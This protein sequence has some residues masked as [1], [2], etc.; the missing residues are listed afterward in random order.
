MKTPPWSRPWRM[1]ALALA[2]ALA[3]GCTISL[4][5][6][7]AVALDSVPGQPERTP[8]Y[9]SPGWIIA[10]GTLHN[11]TIY[12]DGCRTAEDLLKLAQA[13]GMAV[14]AY[15]DHR[16]GK[17]CLG[18]KFCVQTG[19]V[20]KVGYAAYYQHLRRIQEK[21]Q[22]QGMIALKGVEV[23]SPYMAN[24][25]KFPRLV[26]A[27]QFQHFTVYA[28]ED[29]KILEQMPARRGVKLKPEP[30]P[31]DKPFQE[32][33]SYIAEH[34]GIVHAVHVESGQDEWLGPAHAVTPPPIQ[35]MHL[36]NLTGFSILPEGWHEK[37]GGPGGMWDTVLL[38]Y[39]AGMRAKP[40]WASGDADYHGPKGSLANSTTLFY[41]REFTEP[42]IYRAMR[43]GRM[44]ALQGA[45]FQN[46]FVAE[47]WVSDRGKPAEAVMLG[48]EVSMS[49]TPVIRFALDHA[50]PETRVRLI[51]NGR[52]IAEQEGSEMT[53]RDEE[54][55]AKQEPAVY[56]VEVV[57]PRGEGKVYE[58]PLAPES[59]LFVNPIFVR[60]SP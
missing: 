17:F 31:D 46:S 48:Q 6:G 2:L 8:R 57:G 20:E 49:G 37:A 58:T 47:W 40:V 59:E 50:V 11:H 18:K 13:Q 21:A 23:S 28:I 10:R 19:G 22:A 14:L 3:S 4:P 26:L 16:E 36:R 44:V 5:K 1:A 29:P 15:N 60:F 25:G 32:F 9:D 56:R 7:K 55:G 41:L 33:V 54:Q 43:E 24:Y 39:L 45:A 34:G 27:G 42:E 51:R 38:E 53:F 30:I 52:V 35:D 12:S